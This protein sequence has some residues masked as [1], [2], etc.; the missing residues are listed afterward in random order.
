MIRSKVN[1]QN[2][3][4]DRREEFSGIHL[5]YVKEA[6]TVVVIIDRGKSEFGSDPMQEPGPG[7]GSVESFDVLFFPC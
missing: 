7:G 4:V 2:S 5:H 1:I 6:Q 3:M